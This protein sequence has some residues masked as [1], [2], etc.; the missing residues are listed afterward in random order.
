[1]RDCFW[2]VLI[3][4]GFFPLGASANMIQD[5]EVKVSSPDNTLQFR[6]YQ[7]EE[8]NIN[9]LFYE[10]NYK[11]EPLVLP[12]R[13]GVEM[14]NSKWENALAYTSKVAKVGSW[15]D[16]LVFDKATYGEKNDLWKPL[17]GERSSVK[18][19]YRS[20]VISFAKPDKSN[21]RMDIEIR[22]YNEGV[23]FRY[24]F[25]MHPDAIFNSVVADLTEYSLPEDT[26][27]WCAKWAQAPYEE[28][29]IPEWEEG[30]VYERALTL[31]LPNGK[32]A[33]LTDADTDNWCLTNFTRSKSKANTIA[34]DMYCRVDMVTPYATPWKVVMVADTPGKL[35][36]NNDIV[37]N[38]NPPCEIAD[39]SWIKPGKI[40]RET[41]LTTENALACID[42]CAQQNMQYILFDWKWYGPASDYTSD[43]TQVVASIDMKRVIA[44]GKEKGV[45]I[46]LYVNHHALEKQ[47]RELF[48]VLKDWGVAG[49]K[50]GFVQFKTHR[51]A[52]W[53]HDLVRLAAEN[54]LMVN[55][56]DEYRPSGFSR[57]Y[58]NL[59]TQEGIRGNEEFPDATHNTILPFT[60]MLSGAADYTICYYDKRLKTTHAHQLAASVIFYS[61]LLTLFWYDK[62]S[63]YEGEP[64]VEFFKNLPTVFDDTKVLS[65]EP[66]KSAI[67]ARRKGHEWFVGGITNNKG[68]QESVSLSFLEKGKYYLARIYT[69][70][71]D[72]VKTKTHVQCAYFKV[73][74]SQ[75]LKFDLK[76]SGGVAIQLIPMS[77]KELKGYKYYKG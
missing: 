1:M 55:I 50:F 57:T 68:S 30:M 21:Y 12:S 60:R 66:G 34:T 42:F 9:Q 63:L 11:G 62:P 54:H 15:C 76:P 13:M 20:A 59:L 36:E 51:W 7:Q 32:W 29:A 77:E 73:N 65:G 64:E 72:A 33:A 70:G 5:R 71:G 46:W 38:L 19:A 40:M 31:H 28:L 25:P 43:A 52:T 17:Y 67:I 18:D 53:V 23:A 39:T 10:I 41:T 16:N 24:S 4:I 26:K 14:K 6:F 69:D 47:A 56:H 44:Y 74:A 2:I 45:G 48:P 3:L 27:A 37:Q 22:V 8:N 35:L 75:T 61:P 58:P 49:V